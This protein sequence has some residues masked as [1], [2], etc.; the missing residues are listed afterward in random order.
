MDVLNLKLNK[1]KLFEIEKQNRWLESY[2]FISNVYNVGYSEYKVL[3]VRQTRIV[4]FVS[5]ANIIFQNVLNEL[6]RH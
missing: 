6:L 1:L 3:K 5:L 2:F 4:K